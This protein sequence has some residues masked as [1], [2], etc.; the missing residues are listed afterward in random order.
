MLLWLVCKPL[1]FVSDQCC[2]TA[3]AESV[4]VLDAY[5]ALFN[6]PS[7]S[8]LHFGMLY[9][10][11]SHLNPPYCPGCCFS[12]LSLVF[13]LSLAEDKE[14]SCGQ[15]QVAQTHI[16]SLTFLRCLFQGKKICIQIMLTTLLCP[17][18]FILGFL[19]LLQQFFNL[20]H[21]TYSLLLGI[22]LTVLIF[23]LFPLATFF[24]SLIFIYFCFL[25]SFAIS[26]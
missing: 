24:S 21:S 5:P 15:M 26:F 20:F 9:C 17:S 2:P 4:A 12:K 1:S 7:A 22:W 16:T 8:F 25:Y 3:G 6:L 19:L 13:S 10:L 11:R 14:V 23:L 18:T